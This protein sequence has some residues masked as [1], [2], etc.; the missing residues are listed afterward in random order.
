MRLG[1]VVRT[2]AEPPPTRRSGRAGE[3]NVVRLGANLLL[4]A[5][6]AGEVQQAAG[7]VDVGLDQHQAPGAVEHAQRVD[8][9]KASVRVVAR[10]R[11]EDAAQ[12]DGGARL[13]ATARGGVS[14]PAARRWPGRCGRRVLSLA[15]PLAPRI[16]HLGM[17]VGQLAL[18]RAE[19]G[20]ARGDDGREVAE[21]FGLVRVQVEEQ[22]VFERGDARRCPEDAGTGRLLAHGCLR[23]ACGDQQV[24]L[25]LGHG[26]H[27]Y[28]H[29][30]GSL[31][32]ANRGLGPHIG[33]LKGRNGTRRVVDHDDEIEVPRH[34]RQAAYGESGRSHH[35]I[36]RAGLLHGR[37]DAPDGRGETRLAARHG[38]DDEKV[39]SGKYPSR[40]TLQQGSWR[41]ALSLLHAAGERTRLGRGRSPPP[42]G[43]GAFLREVTGREMSLTQRVEELS[44]GQVERRIAMLLARLADQ[45]GSERPGEGTFIPVRLSRQDLADLCGTT[46][47]TAIRVMT[48]LA[49][50]GVVQTVPRG[51]V[52]TCPER[53]ARLAR[54][55]SERGA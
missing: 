22:Q 6:D 34:A 15:D 24:D 3:L 55:T 53:L 36:G 5:L 16:E 48:R 42:T 14:A 38:V 4:E 11:A 33:R 54:G 12:Q 13:L 52:V 21:V 40:A 37:E 50:E 47:E 2:Q 26:I 8:A 17:D 18:G 51:F 27:K 9:L 49:R 32:S 10:I 44:S 31:R 25:D 28:D 43:G 30:L 19:I 23:V 39:H 45:L 20:T 46:I 29:R 1:P 41:R 7:R 35:A